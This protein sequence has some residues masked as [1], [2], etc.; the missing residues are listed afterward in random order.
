MQS[1]PADPSASVARIP[2]IAWLI[3]LAI[4][5]LLAV[6]FHEPIIRMVDIWQAEDSYYSHG[7][8]VP[9]VA[10]FL[11]WRQ[12]ALYMA[13]PPRVSYLGLGILLTGLATLVVSG[14]MV[15]Y[16][17][18]GFGLILVLWGLGG[19]LFGPGALRRLVFPAFILTFM[20]PPPLQMINSIS[21]KMKMLATAMAMRLLDFLGIVAVND[22]QTIYLGSAYVTV[23][24]AC[25]G[26]RSLISLIFLGVLFA[27]FSPLTFPRRVVLFFA[28][29]PIAILS[30][31]LRVAGLSLVAYF[32]G[33][34]AVS[35]PIHD[36]S[37][38]M[39]FVVAFFM[40]YGTMLLLQWRLPAR[41]AAGPDNDD[42]QP[43][44]SLNAPACRK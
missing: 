43:R 24:D 40:L 7:W 8:L 30:N 5:A 12:R 28:S 25:S 37:G 41:P 35:G 32:W 17:T 18:A 1:C 10:I 9:L 33:T 23:G 15:I 19:F 26:L 29:A 34:E 27:Y 3:G 13:D 42:P 16:F 38:Y 21:L 36:I 4:A 31:M 11:I 39:I 2:P 44:P 6:A 20:V 22:G 14:W